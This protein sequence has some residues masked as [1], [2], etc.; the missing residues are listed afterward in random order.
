MRGREFV[1]GDR[2]TVADFLIAY[3]LDWANESQLLD[4]Y[5]VPPALAGTVAVSAACSLATAPILW[6]RFGQVPLLGVV[7]NALVEPV[8]GVLLGLGLVTACV[9]LVAPG[10]AGV[11]AAATAGLPR[12]S[13]PA[14]VVGAAPFAQATGRAPR[15]RGSVRSGR[16]LAGDGGRASTGVPDRRERPTEGR[17]RVA[18]TRRVRARRRRCTTRPS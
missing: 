10:A 13:P 1:V 14:R 11:L 7:A 17:P 18:R 4:G 12:T 15:W 5:P 6:L 16:L 9:D 8:V 3:T 2:V